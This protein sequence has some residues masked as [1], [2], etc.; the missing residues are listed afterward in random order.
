MLRRCIYP[1]RIESGDSHMECTKTIALIIH[2]LDHVVGCDQPLGLISFLPAFGVDPTILCRRSLLIR[3]CIYP[4]RIESRDSQTESTKTIASL[5]IRLI[6]PAFFLIHSFDR[7]LHMTPLRSTS[8][9]HS[10]HS[11][12]SPLFL[13]PHS[14]LFLTTHHCFSL[15]SRPFHIYLY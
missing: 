9:P 13:T 7:T 8:T 10:L 15:P 12:H 1:P 5:S 2:S 14:P 11:P 6:P 3:R 4:P